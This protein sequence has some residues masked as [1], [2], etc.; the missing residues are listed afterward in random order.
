MI[1]M[2]K[3]IINDEDQLIFKSS[4]NGIKPTTNTPNAYRIIIKLL[5][6]SNPEF[7]NYILS[8]REHIQSR[9]KEPKPV[10]RYT[11]HKKETIEDLGFKTRNINNVHQK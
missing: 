6:E 1:S 10:N 8:R 2:I 4:I 3:E 5:Q 11:E 7:Y 9:N